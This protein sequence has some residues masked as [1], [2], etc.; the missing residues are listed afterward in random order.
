MSAS[1]TIRGKGDP[2]QLSPSTDTKTSPVVIRRAAKYEDPI[3]AAFGTSPGPMS[4]GGSCPGATAACWPEGADPTS[5]VC[6][7]GATLRYRA[8]GDLLA[9]NLGECERVLAEGGPRALGERLAAEVVGPAYERAD[10]LGASRLFR[11]FWSGDVWSLPMAQAVAHAATLTGG[12]HWIY[13][14]H[15]RTPV[16][17]A[18]LAA[19]SL[20]VYLSV[21]R[22]NVGTARRV[23]R[24]LSA[25]DRRRVHV[26]P[27]AA[28]SE[29]ARDLAAEVRGDLAAEGPTLT[30][31]VG[32][33]GAWRNVVPASGS[34]RR[35]VEVGERAA[36][37]C[38]RCGHC[39]DG[40]GDVLFP[41]H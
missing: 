38:S 18:L 25:D 9:R 31:P 7:V 16:V 37:A 21:D 30:C 11:W 3:R 10:R 14:R 27:M 39:V 22:Y 26:A 40:R 4:Q 29:E 34:I 6:Y 32:N 35:T 28:T 17:R 8:V 23:L 24:S 33:R 19:P 15:H 12:R 36:G 20:S 13:T 5:A 2:V 1:V 41:I